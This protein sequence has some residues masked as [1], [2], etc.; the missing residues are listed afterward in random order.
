MAAYDTAALLA[1]VKRRGFTPTAQGTFSA[2]EVLAVATEELNSYLAPLM[3]EVREEYFAAYADLPLVASQGAYRVPAR[4]LGGKLRDVVWLDASGTPRNLVRLEPEGA[5]RYRASDLGA[6]EAFSL[7]GNYVL[8]HPT[9]QTGDGHLRLSYFAR[10]GALVETSAAR[11]VV[12]VDYDA[13][14]VTVAGA[15]P[16][17]FV[18]GAR[19]D[20]VQAQPSFATV[21]S[22]LTLTALATD[23]DGDAVLTFAAL[24]RPEAVPLDYPVTAP[25]EISLGDWVC[26]AG[27]SPVPQVPPE[28]HPLLALKTAAAMLE[29]VG[30]VEA[31]RALLAEL[32]EKQRRALAL[33][34]PR[35]E[36]EQRKVRNGFAKW[37]GGCRVF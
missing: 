25:E 33:L 6:P 7:R 34:S 10:P 17:S 31:A 35:V 3:L 22:E 32:G 5:A 16:A 12:D 2:A 15:A 30:D 18:V 8:L 28:L 21:G 13:L 37:R 19:L 14:S 27:E 1:M 29:A 11:A 20:V 9:P 26:L 36:G 23:G 24:P 4:A